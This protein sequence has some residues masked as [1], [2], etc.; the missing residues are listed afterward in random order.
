M[1]D[2]GTVLLLLAAVVAAILVRIVFANRAGVQ[3]TLIAIDRLSTRPGQL[4]GWLIIALTLVITYYVSARRFFRAP[5]D[6]GLDASYMLYGGLFMLAGAYTLSRNGH[7]RGELSWYRNFRPRTQ[8]KLDL[9]LYLLFFFPGIIAFMVAGW[10]YFLSNPGCS[11]RAQSVVSP[12]GPMIW[13]SSSSFPW[14]GP[15]ADAGLAEALRCVHVH[16]HRRLAAAPGVTSRS[17]R[18]R[19]SRRAEARG[20]EALAQEMARGGGAALIEAAHAAEE[21]AFRREQQS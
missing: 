4:G 21:R 13:P 1:T 2:R 17:W 12:S 9:V 11:E 16:P 19:S 8:A 5:T 14:S 6:L 18:S 20:A 15:D 10:R 7:V 3:R